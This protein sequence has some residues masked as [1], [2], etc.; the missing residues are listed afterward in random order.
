MNEEE[1]EKV[2]FRW[3]VAFVL[4]DWVIWPAFRAFLNYK[5]GYDPGKW[6][7]D[8]PYEWKGK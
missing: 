2:P 5:R 8:H 6:Y 1:K 3:K 4:V 7:R